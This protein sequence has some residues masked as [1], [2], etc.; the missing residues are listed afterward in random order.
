VEHFNVG[1]EMH[2]YSRIFKV[3]GCD[4]FTHNFLRKLGVRI[5]PASNIPG[6][7]YTDH[8]KQV[9]TLAYLFHLK[10]MMQ[11]VDTLT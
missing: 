8:R 4:E 11:G 3:T 2:F 9:I 6:D 10:A 5:T 1:K 7:P